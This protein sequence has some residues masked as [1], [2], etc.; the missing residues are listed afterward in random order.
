MREAEAAANKVIKQEKARDSC[1]RE[2]LGRL[3]NMGKPTAKDKFRITL[4]GGLWF[5]SNGSLLSFCCPRRP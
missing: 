3:K 4:S 1:V 5:A 2:L